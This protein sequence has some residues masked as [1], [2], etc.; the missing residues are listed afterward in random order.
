MKLPL[1]LVAV[2]AVA[3]SARAEMPDP[4]N[5]VFSKDGTIDFTRKIPTF[6]Q[7]VSIVDSTDQPG[8]AF[9]IVGADQRHVIRIERVVFGSQAWAPKPAGPVD[10][11]YLKAVMAAVR[12]RGYTAEKH[13]ALLKTTVET[14]QDVAGQKTL[15]VLDSLKDPAATA[16]HLPRV[17]RG[18]LVFAVANSVVVVQYDTGGKASDGSHP[19]HPSMDAMQWLAGHLIVKDV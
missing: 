16:V 17:V 2:L 7:P 13:L 12:Q 18:Y 19:E 4:A 3:V 14:I 1:L 15:I 5:A 9:T 11:A 6:G 8:G 10:E